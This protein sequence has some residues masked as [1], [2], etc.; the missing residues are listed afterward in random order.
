VERPY[1]YFIWMLVTVCAKLVYSH[2]SIAKKLP[3]SSIMILLGLLTGIFFFLVN[4]KPITLTPD[5]FFLALLPPIIMEA[6]YF[7]PN[8]LFFDQLGT[9]L[10][11]AVVGTIFNM[12]TIGFTLYGVGQLGW[13]GEELKEMEYLEVL[14]FGSLIAAV[15]PVAV[16]AV[17]EEIK[18]DEVLNIV[19]FGESL[20]NDGV[21]VVLYHMF[22]SFEEMGA[23]NITGQDIGFGLISF[24]VVAGGGTLIGIIFGYLCSL[25]TRWMKPIAL[26]ET[27][28][29]LSMAYLSY[30]TAEIFHMS[31]I[32][33]I[34]FCGITMKNYVEK[35]IS[36]K[37][38]ST[39]K[40]AMHILANVAEMTIF[41][42]LGVY[43]LSYTTHKWNT[44]FIVATIVACLFWRVMGVL[45]L[46]QLANCIRIKKMDGVEQTIMMYGG[47]R[48]GVAFALVLSLK[49]ANRDMFVTA[50]LAMVFFT[51]FFQG[52]TIKPL[53]RLLKVKTRSSSSISMGDRVSSRL[54]DL[55][56][57]GIGSIVETRSEIPLLCRQAYKKFDDK[58]LSPL[59]HREKLAEPK[60]FET[61][62]SLQKQDAY[63]HLHGHA[64]DGH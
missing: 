14:L 7:M 21:A 57:T 55:T 9:I 51:V 3:E 27:L 50:T 16:L 19:V 26:M 28:V 23:P 62:S 37:S 32:L 60:F 13:Y 58:F 20:L 56:K 44:V 39:I 15:D 18:V 42:F 24:L 8:R 38:S 31:G 49:S 47:L 63:K 36:E 30:L 22:E 46:A 10:L 33:S 29:V 1:A 12:F 2:V 54:M 4:F 11:M 61:F 5:I 6:G 53:V 59:L 25:L 48:G 35:N 52:I 43:T 40:M 64:D 34:T 41:L 45:L 17:F